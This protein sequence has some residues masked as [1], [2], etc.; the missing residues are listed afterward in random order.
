MIKGNCLTHKTLSPLKNPDQIIPAE[1][2]SK[3]S[4]SLDR[5]RHSLHASLLLTQGRFY[6]PISGNETG[7]SDQ[8]I[9]CLR[10]RSPASKLRH[11]ARSTCLQPR[12]AEANHS[13]S[14]LV[15][16]MST[17]TAVTGHCSDHHNVLTTDDS[18]YEQL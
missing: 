14:W 6:G 9:S 18:N 10:K 12:T 11:K 7:G 17:V 13:I 8:P 2:K 15:G 3:L 1:L 16:L 4:R 5:E